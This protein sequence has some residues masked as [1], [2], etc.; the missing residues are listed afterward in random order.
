M[1]H[2]PSETLFGGFDIRLRGSPGGRYGSLAF[3]RLDMIFV[4]TKCQLMFPFVLCLFTLLAAL[5]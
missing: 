5:P 1:S 2:H 3:L 4:P